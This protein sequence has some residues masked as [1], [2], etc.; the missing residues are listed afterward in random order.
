MIIIYNILL[1]S[2]SVHAIPA[3]IGKKN[4]P[5]PVICRVIE[6]NV[7]QRTTTVSTDCK[8]VFRVL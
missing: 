5:I 3:D 4:K 6:R 7:A 1:P 2:A 8:I